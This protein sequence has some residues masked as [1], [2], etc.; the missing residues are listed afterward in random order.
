VL[1]QP[2][3]GLQEIGFFQAFHR[4]QKHRFGTSKFWIGKR[5]YGMLEVRNDWEW[6]DGG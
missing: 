5:G 1:K 6:V 3:G 2:L 4:Q